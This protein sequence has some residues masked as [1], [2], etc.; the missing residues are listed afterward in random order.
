MKVLLVGANPAFEAAVRRM[1]GRDAK[2][3][4]FDAGQADAH[5][6][7]V[8]EASMSPRLLDRIR[9]QVGTT[10]VLVI[11]ADARPLHIQAM[12]ENLARFKYRD[13]MERFGHQILP[14]YLSA[15]LQ[16]HSGNVTKAALA[17]GLE[18][19]SLHRLMR[20]YRIDARDFRD[21]QV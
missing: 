15:L 18:R 5:L 19:E 12:P 20:R 7:V 2:L 8:E 17:V 1:V 6:V 21:S 3:E 4:S 16:V 11:S 13:V 9:K 14:E 10:P